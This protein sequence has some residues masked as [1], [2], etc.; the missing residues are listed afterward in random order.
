MTA[1]TAESVPT[2][3]KVKLHRTGSFETV[4][5]ERY[6]DVTYIRPLDEEHCLVENKHGK[7]EQVKVDDIDN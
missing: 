1:A 7:L 4:P 3:T 5:F 2:G 6:E